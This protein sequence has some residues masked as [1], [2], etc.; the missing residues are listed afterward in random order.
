M[1]LAE[2]RQGACRNNAMNGF[3][4]RGL[5]VSEEAVYSTNANTK[6]QLAKPAK[7]NFGEGEGRFK[8]AAADILLGDFFER[9]WESQVEIG[10]RRIR[11]QF[12]PS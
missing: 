12:L 11:H 1:R 10:L 8:P 5:Q 9:G 2:L 7:N 6:A 3:K 4:V